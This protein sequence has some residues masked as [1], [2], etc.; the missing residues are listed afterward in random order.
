MKIGSQFG[1][2]QVA[3]VSGER[4]RLRPDYKTGVIMLVAG[5][6][7]LVI[8]IVLF[9]DRTRHLL[10]WAPGW[11]KGAMFIL[12]PIGILWFFVMTGRS[13]LID[14]PA[15]IARRTVY[16]FFGEPVSLVS[17]TGVQLEVDKESAPSA[18]EFVKL[19]LL[20]AGGS[21]VFEIGNEKA[22]ADDFDS[23]PTTDFAMLLEI[24]RHVAGMLKLP[25]EIKGEPL[26]MS[27]INRKMLREVAAGE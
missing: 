22:S 23:L 17:V 7:F 26:R 5:L 2:Y 9:S 14:V 15:G 21:K 25:L 13:L 24:A 6:A 3:E 12:P 4:L 19:N 1:S 16:F 20:G 11:F 18:G 10:W 27:E 8:D